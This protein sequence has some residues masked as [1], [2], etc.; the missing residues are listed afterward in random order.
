MPQICWQYQDRDISNKSYER[1]WENSK[2]DELSFSLFT[3]WIGYRTVKPF[4]QKITHFNVAGECVS[5]M[6]STFTTALLLLENTK[7]PLAN[8]CVTPA[9]GEAQKSLPWEK[10]T[11]FSSGSN[12]AVHLDLVELMEIS[13]SLSDGRRNRTITDEHAPR[14]QDFSTWLGRLIYFPIFCFMHSMSSS[15]QKLIIRQKLCSFLD[16]IMLGAE[17]SVLLL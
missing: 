7:H 14:K 4:W 2:E 8:L 1:Y 17:P 5:K 3:L 12:V 13:V 10:H 11:Y 9:K 6:E 16:Q 15:V